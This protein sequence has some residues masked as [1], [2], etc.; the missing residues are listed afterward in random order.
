[1]AFRSKPLPPK[2]NTPRSCFWYFLYGGILLWFGVLYYFHTL[3]NHVVSVTTNPP[4]AVDQPFRET[5]S[6]LE[7]SAAT[8]KP[9]QQLQLRVREEP[10]QAVEDVANDDLIHIVFSTDC[11]FFQDWQTLL[12]F[13]SAVTVKQKGQI[14]RIAS[15][16]DEFK[17]KELLELY[18][19]LF[20]QY[21]VHF[22]P[23]FKMD[24]KTKKKY[25]FYNK[26]YGLH[27]WLQYAQ[28]AIDPG[29]IVILID[30][31]MIL[32]RPFTLAFAQNPAN[33]FLPTFNPKKDPI[34]T[35]IMKGHP[36]AQLY[37]LGA[38][39]TVDKTARNFNRTAICGVD[40]P[41]MKVTRQYGEDHYSVGP[42]Y[43]LEKD[44]LLRLTDTWTTF[45]PRYVFLLLHI[46][47]FL[48]LST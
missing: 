32:L 8:Q 34:P 11:S 15:G 19:K 1:M 31:D 28:P 30:P 16:C 6:V 13:H 48:R 4:P 26:P 29:V 12:V 5:K 46:V 3:S 39:W 33:L 17:Q 24:S 9:P 43:I 22:T 21:H 27:H 23:D 44:D 2:S 37:G 38:P 25:D 41:C 14:T 36:I 20:P 42:P 18:Q 10:I 35:V 7:A 40:S 45:V 47:S